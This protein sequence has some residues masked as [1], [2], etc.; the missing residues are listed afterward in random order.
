MEPSANTL[1]Q[2]LIPIRG[3]SIELHK[4]ANLQ[5]PVRRPYT[6]DDLDDNIAWIPYPRSN[7]IEY[8]EKPGV[9][10]Y[11]ATELANLAEITAGTQQLFFM[12]TCHMEVNDLWRRTNQI[13][14]R[15]QQWFENMPDVLKTDGNAVP[16]VVFLS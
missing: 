4:D 10:R 9:L 7:Q 3:M 1:E 12:N 11:V 5:P 16:Q 15:L 2:Q 14:S 8:A 6:P 13:Y